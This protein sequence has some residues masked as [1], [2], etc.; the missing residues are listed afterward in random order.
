MGD[1][2]G[3]NRPVHAVGVD[4]IH[5]VRKSEAVREV[6]FFGNQNTVAKP[7]TSKWLHTLQRLKGWAN[8]E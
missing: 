3:A 7:A 1:S 5:A 2:R 4:W 8:R 6:G